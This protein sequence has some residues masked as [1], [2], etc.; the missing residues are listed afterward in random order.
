MYFSR[1]LAA[2]PSP[3]RGL[4]ASSA[5]DRSWFDRRLTFETLDPRILLSADL[6]PLHDNIVTAGQINR[7]HLTLAQP[8]TI[9]ADSGNTNPGLSWRLDAGNIATIMP[10]S[11]SPAATADLGGTAKLSLPAGDYTLSV[12]GDVNA[13]GS[14]DL[15]LLDTSKAATIATGTPT[16]G[17]L[18]AGQADLYHFDGQ[19]GE[20]VFLDTRTMSGVAPAFHLVGPNGELLGA[21]DAGSATLGP[22]TLD[23]NGEYTLRV[24][25][26]HGASDYGFTVFASTA[27][28]TAA[29]TDEVISGHLAAPG[30]LA[31]Y[32]FSVAQQSEIGLD[33]LSGDS[34]LHFTLLGSA[35][36]AISDWMA[37]ATTGTQ[38][39]H[40][41]IL[42]PG[43]Y[44][45]VVRDTA[46][47]PSD[48][49]F[50]AFDPPLPAA[51]ADTGTRAP[52][53]SG[54]LATPGQADQYSFTL[55]KESLLYFD[56]VTNNDSINWS[57]TGPRGA[58]VNA[59]AFSSSDAENVGSPL[60]TL[61]AGNYTLSVQANG[62]RTGAYGFR[63]LDLSKAQPITPGVPVTATL[64]ANL[65]NETD[66][67]SFTANAGQRLYLNAISGGNIYWRL[68][69]PFGNIIGSPNY[70][71]DQSIT[72]TSSGTYTLLV[73]GRI[74]SAAANT[75]SF[76]VNIDADS[77]A[78]LVLGQ[79]T[80]GAVTQP[81]QLNNYTFAQ[82]GETR[83]V[84][85]ALTLDTSLLWSLTGPAGQVIRQ[86]NFAS[87]DSLSIGGDSTALDLPGGAYTLTVQGSGAH[88]SQYA[89]RLLDLS[90]GTKT[91]YDT[92]ISA[93]LGDAGA[94]AA[95]VAGAAATD[96]LLV[97][98]GTINNAVNF[99][100]T[101]AYAQVADKAALRP[102]QVTVEAW[103]YYDPN[104]P[105][106]GTIA[107]K[108]SNGSWQDG[109]GL[110]RLPSGVGFY[111]N[112]YNNHFITT[113]LT[114]NAW[115]HVAAT[116]D[117]TTMVL[118]VNGVAVASQA[119][120]AAIVYNGST[121]ANAMPLQIGNAVGG[122]SWSGQIDELQ[123]WNVARSAADIAASYQQAAT[124]TEAGLVGLWHFDEPS[125][126]TTFADASPNNAVATLVNNAPGRE[127]RVYTFDAIAGDQVQLAVTQN[128]NSIY[129]RL[130]DPYGAQV[131]AGSLGNTSLQTL[132][133]TGTYALL[134][135][136]Y[137]YNS[138][139]ASYTFMIA[140]PSSVPLPT[141]TGIALTLGTPVSVPTTTVNETDDYIF[142]I[143]GPA[144]FNFAPLTTPYFTSLSANWQL[145]GPQGRVTGPNSFY[146]N[147]F[148]SLTVPGTYRLRVTDPTAGQHYSFRLDDET[149]GAEVTY[150]TARSDALST[151][152]DT[153]YYTFTAAAGDRVYFEVPSVS[154]SM[155]WYLLD[156]YTNTVF[157]QG[158]ASTGPYTMAVGGTYTLVIGGQYYNSTPNSS[159][160]F[161][162]DQIVD[163]TAAM[164]LGST[165]SGTLTQPGQTADYTFSLANPAQ[166]YFAAISPQNG[167]FYWT[168]TGPSGVVVSNTYLYEPYNRELSLPAGNY[169]LRISGN[170]AAIGAFSFRMLDLATA[171]SF[172]YGDVVT[173]ASATSPLAV[174]LYKFNAAAGDNVYFNTLANSD[175][176]LQWQVLDPFGR[177]FIS[178]RGFSTIGR[179]VLPYAGAYTVVVDAAY[180]DPATTTNFSFQVLKET[181]TTTAL[182]AVDGPA[183]TGPI[184]VAGPNGPALSFTGAE[185]VAVPNSAA[186]DL[187]NQ[188]TIS[189]W[190]NPTSFQNT[191]AN[192]VY[193]GDGINYLSR[194]YS[195]WLNS[196]GSIYLGTSDASGHQSLQTANG[197]IRAGVWTYVTAEFDR[198]S[199]S[200]AVY[201]NGV[202]AVAG[203]LRTG[204]AVDNAGPLV[205]GGQ[206]EAADVGADAFY[207]AMQ[208]LSISST[209]LNAA[210]V[211]S[212]YTTTL[213]G[214]EANLALYLPMNEATGATALTD[215]SANN[216]PV[217]VTSES[218]GL[219][220][221]ITGRFATPG[222]IQKYTF[223]LLSP[224]QL[225]FDGLT[226]NSNIT[227]TLTGPNGLN[228][229]RNLRNGDSFEWGST[230]PVIQ[231][232][233]GSYTITVADSSSAL[234]VYAF[235]FVNLADAQPV[236]LN[237]LISGALS[238]GAATQA[239]RFTANAGDVI[240]LNALS[241]SL[242]IGS[243]YTSLRLID[244]LGNQVFGPNYF[245]DVG[246]T[247]LAYTGTYTLLVEG[248]SWYP[249]PET[250]SFRINPVVNQTVALTLGTNPNP[251]PVWDETSPPTTGGVELTGAEYVS[252][253]DSAALDA[254]GDVTIEAWIKVDR[255]PQTWAPI[256]YKGDATNGNG[257]GRTYSLWLNSNGSIY[258]G[259]AAGPGGPQGVQTGGGLVTPGTWVH[260]AGVIDRT[261]GQVHAYVN[262]VDVAD[263]GISTV[264]GPVAAQ[265]L[266]IGGTQ[267]VNPAYS[268]F[269]GTVS[270]VRV[271]S[272]VRS[273]SQILA[274]KNTALVGTEAN[275]VLDLPF[276]EGA[277][278]TTADISPNAGTATIQRL[279]A[280][281]VT[282]QITSPG[283]QA[284]YTFTLAADRQ[285]YFDA[286]LADSNLYWTLSGPGGT[287]VSG[288]QFT[289]SDANRG[290][291]LLSL[292]AG[293][294]QLT[295]NFGGA[296]TGFYNFR[297]LDFSAAT[298][299]TL[300]TPVNVLLNP[301]NA[302]NI[303]KF[304]ATAGERV[305][306]DQLADNGNAYFRVIDPLGRD[307]YGAIWHDSLPGFGIRTLSLDGT[308]TIIVDS[309][310]Y[311]DPDRTSFTFNVSQVIDKTAAMTSGTAVQG[312]ID[313]PGQ[314]ANYT[315]TVA[316]PTRAF[317]DSLTNNSGFYWTITG[318]NGTVISGRQFQNAD[319]YD[320][321]GSNEL[322][323]APGD[324]TVT[325]TGYQD[326]TGAFSFNLLDG[327]AATALTLGTPVTT[328]QTA[329]TT[330]L[331]SFT[332]NQLDRVQL[333]SSN[334][335]GDVS[336]RLLDPLGRVVFGPTY[337]GNSQGIITLPLSGTYLLEI[338]GR[339]Y[340]GTPISYTLNVSQV[341]QPASGGATTQDFETA[342]N[343]LPWVNDIY[344]SGS[345]AQVVVTGGASPNKFLRLASTLN[346]NQDNN[347]SFSATGT[348]P[349]GSVQV[350]YD[351][352]MA[353]GTGRSGGIL[354]SL[355]DTG[356]YGTGGP[357]YDPRNGVSAA[358][359]VGLGAGGAANGASD[360]VAVYRYNATLRQ[361]T[362]PFN[363]A[364]GNFSHARVIAQQVD[365]GAQVTVILTPSGGG[366]PVTVIDH[367]FIGGWFPDSFRLVFNG[368]TGSATMN[369]DIDNLAIA[370]TPAAPIPSMTLDSIV[371]GNIVT[372][373]ATERY[374]FTP[375]APTSAVF[376]SLAN[377]G[378]LY[379]SI[380]GP[381]GSVISGRQFQN[382]DSWD[383]GGTS[384]VINLATSTY[385]VSIA[386]NDSTS[387][388][389]FSFRLNQL[390]TATPL[391]IGTAVN[392]TLNPAAGTGLYS[393]T[394]TAGDFFYLSGLS[395]W[396]GTQY[397]KVLDPNGT[398]VLFQQPLYQN[399]GFTA[400]VSGTY[401]LLIEGRYYATGAS[402]F[403]FT[404]YKPSFTTTALT[405]NTTVSDSIK[406]PGA[407]N[408]YSFTL[409]APT[410]L[411]WNSQTNDYDL[412]YV[413]TGPGGATYLVA[414]S[415]SD[416]T[417]AIAYAPAGQYTLTIYNGQNDGHTGPYS[418]R[419]LD[420]IGGATAVTPGTLV[421]DT[422][423][424][425]TGQAAY[426]ITTRDTDQQLY[427]DAPTHS[428]SMH[429][430]LVNRAGG[431]LF[432]SNFQ[433][434]GFLTLAAN[435]T[436]ALVVSGYP[437]NG[438]T[439]NYT[440]SLQPQT[441]TTSALVLGAVTSGAISIAGETNS[442]TFTLANPTRL[443]LGALSDTI[444]NAYPYD[445]S[446]VA[447][448]TGPGGV[449][450]SRYLNAGAGVVYNNYYG[451]NSPIFNLPAGLYTLTISSSNDSTG[452]YSFRLQDVGAA[453]PI[454][455][456]SPVTGTLSPGSDSS[457]FTFTARAGDRIFVDPTIAPGHNLYWRLVDPN[458]AQVF[459]QYGNTAPGAF[460]LSVTGTYTLTLEG[461]LGDAGAT[462]SFGFAVYPAPLSAP[463]PI[464]T[465]G[466]VLAPDLTVTNLAANATPRIQAGGS[467][468]V[469][470][471][472][473]NIGAQPTD[474]SWTDRVVVRRAD[475]NQI[476]ANVTVPYDATALGALPPD[477]GQNQHISFQLPDGD[478]GSGALIISV[479]T[480]IGNTVA[481]RNGDGTAYSNNTATLNIMSVL[482]PYPDLQVK[483][484]GVSPTT[485]YKPGDQVTVSWT[486]V[487]A[488]TADVTV[489]FQEQ[490]SVRNL[491][492]G[493]VILL[494]SQQFS[495]SQ[496][497]PFAA[498]ATA[499]RSMI[500][501]WPSGFNSTGQFE[502]DITVD[503][504][505]QVIEAVPFVSRTDNTGSTTALS[506]PD[507]A[508]SGLHVVSPTTPRS[509]STVTIGWT[510][511]NN[512]N[513]VTPVGWND[514]VRVVNLTTGALIIV[515]AVDAGGVLAPGATRARSFAF[516]LPDGNAGVG[517]IQVTVTLDQTPQGQSAIDEAN[518]THG[519]NVRANNTA[520]VNFTSILAL[521]PDLV[522]ALM[523][524]ATGTGGATINV[525]WTVTNNGA[526]ATAAGSWS[527]KLVLSSSPTIGAASDVVLGFFPHTGDLAA[528]ASY[529]QTQTVT[530]P[531]KLQGNYYI[532]VVADTGQAVLEPNTRAD[533]TSTVQPIAITSPAADLAPSNVTA[534]AS[535][536]IGG[537]VTIGWNV[538]NNGSQT[539][540]LASWND[541][542][543]LSESTTVQ[544]GD[545]LLATIPHVG[546]L[547]VGASYNATTTVNLPTN[548]AGTFNILVVTNADGL[549]Y[550]NGQTGNNTAASGTIVVHSPDL[551]A[552]TLTLPGLTVPG[553]PTTATLT[554]RNDGDAS[555]TA[556]WSDAIYLST[557]PS[558]T[559][560]TY[561]TQ[562]PHSA[563][564]AGGGAYTVTIPLTLPQFSDGTYYLV[565]QTD[566]GGQVYEAARANN[567]VASAGFAL[568]HPDL[569]P[570]GA[571]APAS[572]TS[573]QP[574]TVTWSD[575]NR[576]TGPVLPGWTDTV[577]LSANGAIDANAV[578]LGSVSN[579]GPLAAGGAIAQSLTAT[580]PI[581][582]SGAYQVLIQTDSNNT[583]A[584]LPANE[585]NN[586]V[587]LPLTVTLAPYADLALSNV[588][589]PALTV[590]DP[591]TVTIG[592]TVTNQGT[593]IGQ[594]T[595]WDDAVIASPDA[596]VG[597]GDDIVIGRFTHDGPL[598]V[599][600]SYTQ[601]QQI[602]LAPG[603]IGRYHLFVQADAGRVVFQNGSTGNDAAQLATPFDVSP[604]PYAD[605]VVSSVTPDAGGSSG[606]PLKLTWTVQNQGIGLTD[607]SDWQD[608]VYISP[609]ADGSGSTYLGAFSHIGFITPGQG[610]TRSATVT[611]PDTYSGPAYFFVD[612]PGSINPQGGSPYEFIYTNNNRGFS[613]QTQIAATPSPDLIVSNIIVPATASE[614]SAVDV[615]W[616]V[617]NQG[618][619][620][621]DGS[622]TDQVYLHKVGDTG[623][624]TAIGSYT[625]T[626]PLGAGLSY[627]RREQI[628]LPTHTSDRYEVIVTT[629]ADS[630][631]FER[632]P[633]DA[634]DTTVSA[635]A[636]LVSVLPRPDLQIAS[637]EAPDTIDAGAS[638]SVAF[639]IINQG[640]V[641]T[642]IPHWTDNV[643]LS[644]DSKI[645]SDDIVISS[646]QNGSALDPGQS[647]RTEAGSFIVPLRFRGTVY[648][649][650]E[651]NV[652]RTMDEWPN[653]DNNISIHPLY[654]N[655]KPFAD[656]VVSDV[657]TPALSFEGN[658]LTVTY[659]VTNRGA[660]PTNLGNYAEQIWLT[661]DKHRPSPSK[662]DVLLKEIQYTGGILAVGQGYDRSV[663]VTLPDHVVSGTYYITPWVDPYETLLQ[664]E[665]AINVNPD[666]PH[667]INNDNYKAGGA[668]V[669]GLKVIGT[670]A[671]VPDLQVVS[672]N[673]DATGTGG[674]TFKAS[675]TVIN[676]GDGT[677]T[678]VTDQVFLADQPTLETPGVNSFYL[679]SF[680]APGDLAPGKSYTQ[681]QSFLLN[682]AA[683][684]TYFIV[685]NQ[686]IDAT[687][688]DNENSAATNVVAPLPDLQVTSVQAAASAD[689]GEKTSITY[690]VTNTGAAA[691]WSGTKY[692][693]DQIWISRDSTFIASRAINV[694]SVEH[695]GD[696]LA[697]GASY[698]ETTN[699]TLPPG[700]GGT[701]H[702]YVFT[703]V[704][705]S[706]APSLRP[707]PFNN[708]DNA[709]L[710]DQTFQSAA[711]EAPTGNMGTTILPVVYKEPDLKVTD[712]V[713]PATI[714]AG[715]T[716]DISFTVTN[717]GNR[718][719][720]E[721]GWTDRVYLSLDASL[722][723]GDYLLPLRK[724]D[725]TFADAAFLRQGVL[726][727][728]DS[729]VA[730]IR[731]TLPFEVKGSFYLLAYT[732]SG[733]GASGF[734]PST[735]S[736]R[737]QGIAGN[738]GGVVREFQGEGNNV[739]AAAVQITP[740]VAPDLQVTEVDAPLR[741]TRGQSFSV[742]YT[743]T[744][745]GGD[746]PDL[747]PAWDDLIYLSRDQL[748]DL[749]ADR[750]IGTLRHTTGLAAGAAYTNTLTFSVPSDL[751]TDAYYV[752]VV[753][754]PARYNATGEVFES[755]ERNNA[756]PS[757]A[758]MVID[759]PPPTDLQVDEVDGPA[760]ARAGEPIHIS[761]NVSDHSATVPAS[762]A[763]T[764]AV[765]LSPDA[766]WHVTDPV[767]G[768]ITFSGTLA[769]AQGYTL[770][771]DGTMPAAAPGDYR[772]IVR[773][774]IYHQ[775]YEGVFAANNTTASANATTVSVD[776]LTLGIPLTTTLMAGQARLYQLTV[777]EGQTLRVKLT[778][779]NDKS[780]NTIY[781]R[782]D[783]A[784]TT[785]VYDATSTGAL[786]S[787]LSALVPSTLPGTY[788]VLVKGFT[789]PAGGSNITLLAEDLPLLIT[790][791]QSDRGGDSKF[792]TVTVTGA[793]FAPQAI[794]KLVRPDIAEYEPVNWQV[795]NSAEI[796]ATF[797]LTDAPHGLYDLVVTNPDG[798]QA[799]IP[800]RFLVE[801]AVEPEVTIGIG[802]P[803]V[804]LAGDT[805][806]YSI[807][808]DNISNLDAPYT[809]FQVGI[810]QLN[811]N[812]IV[813]GLP[814]VT[815]ATNVAGAPDNQAGSAN[816]SVPYASIDSITNT[817]GQLITSGYLF[818][819]PDGG[820]AGF[821]VN[822][823]TYPGLKALHDRA[824]DAFRAEMATIA[825]DLDSKLAN[826]PGGLQ[827]WWD[828][829]KQKAADV[830]PQF[831]DILDQ[832]DF[833]GLYNQ[834]EAVPN[835]CVVPFIPFRF[836]IFAAATSMTRDEFIAHI[837]NE[838]LTIRD[839][840]LASLTTAAP[841]PAPLI[842]LVADKQ[843]FVDLELAALEQ[844][845]ILR[846]DGA[847]PPIRTRQDIQSLMSV[848]ASGILFGPAGTD[849]RSTGDLLSF[850]DQ[851]RALYGNN[852]TTM[853]ALDGYDERMSDC[854]TY[855]IPLPSI[856]QFSDYNLNLSQPTQF[857]AFRV[858]VPW[859]PFEDRGA[860]L[861]ADFQ[862][863]LAAPVE[864]DP[865]KALDFSRYFNSQGQ[866]N[867][868]ASITGPQ[869]LDSQGYL[870]VNTALP[871][872]VNFENSAAASTYVNS[873][874]I[875]TQL[876]PSLDASTFT[877]GDI[878]V[879]DITVHV[880]A[881]QHFFSQDIDFTATRGFILRVTA[882][883]DLYQNPAAATWLIQAID[884]LTGEVLTDATRGLLKPNDAQGTGAGFVS[885][886]A[887]AK[888]DIA[889]GTHI[890]AKARV[891][892]DT[893]PPEDTETLDQVV[894]GLPPTSTVTVKQLGGS[895]NYA[896]TWN[897]T[898]DA[899]GSGFQHVTL[900]VA[901]DGGDFKIWQRQLTDATGT[902]VY[903]GQAGHTYEFLALA[904]DN[905]GNREAPPTDVVAA[906]DGSQPT[907]GSTPSVPDTTPANF[908]IPPTPAPTPSTNPLFTAAE[909]DLPSVVPVTHASEFQSVL[910]PFAAQSFA[911]GVGASEAGIA[912]V[913]LLE[914]PDGTFLVAG[915]P[916]RGT[917]YKVP[918]DG[919]ANATVW[920]T[921]DQPVFNMAFDKA[922]RL[923][924]TTGG[925][926]LLRLDPVS[927][928]VLGHYGDGITLALAVDPAGGT[929]YVGTNKGVSTF[930]PDTGTFT[931]WSRDE[932]LRVSSLAF[933]PDGALWGVTW[934]DRRQVVRF[935]DHKRAVTQL[936]FD[937]DIDSIAFGQ[938]GTALARLLFVSHNA[939]PVLDTGAA[940][941][942]SE[943]TM[944]DVAT[945]R[946]VALATGGTRGGDLI[947]TSDGRV[948][949][950]QSH[951]VDVVNPVFAPSVIATNPPDKAV[952]PLPL[953]YLS[954]TFD[955][956]MLAA[957]AT[958]AGS[959]LNPANYV[960][961]GAVVGAVTPTAI[962]Y[963]AATRTV[964]LTV[965]TLLADTYTLTIRSTV[966]SA[967]ALTLGK[968]YTVSFQGLDDLTGR[969][970]IR[971]AGTR[972]DRQTGLISYDL[973]ITNTSG[974]DL[975][976]PALLVLD[977]R[978]GATG[979]PQST[980]GRT[981]DGRWLVDLSASLPA[982]GKL[983]VGASITGTTVSISTPD[984]HREDFSVGVTAN[985]A[986][987]HAPTF[988][989]TPPTAAI[990]VG[991]VFTYAARA[992]DAD[993]NAIIYRLLDGPDNMTMDPATGNVSWVVPANA[994]AS[995]QV[996]LQVFDSHGASTVQSFTITVT[997]GNQPPQ[998][999]GLASE[1000]DGAEGQQISFIATGTDPQSLP[1001]VVTA[1002]GLPPGS[1003]FDP[1004]T[1005]TF[1006][1007][1008]PGYDQAGTYKNA[1009][1010]SISDGISTVTQSVTFVISQAAKPVRL[1011]PAPARTLREGDRLVFDLHGQGDA[1012]KTLTYSA[1013]DLPYGATLDP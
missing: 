723:D 808:L 993:G 585:A 219:P 191:W 772:I 891:L 182:P 560:T 413:L 342:G 887:N 739:T 145:D 974:S 849:I 263:A 522:P 307:L 121:A 39:N 495:A 55:S 201:L 510:D 431:V 305:Y 672:V 610:Y 835:D 50:R 792:V 687:P 745:E 266:L 384:P 167:N 355:V 859:V 112:S 506:A 505:G 627:T 183:I 642:T 108:A 698:T 696:S 233:A 500:F 1010:F 879:G 323:L 258:I 824:F 124:G 484:V 406:Q 42:D 873:I 282:G 284:I 840:I 885:W 56:S 807:A 852:D 467:V 1001:L 912:P 89:F 49:T 144:R 110:A 804:I 893:Q 240:Y 923:W 32:S 593:G 327:G 313:V 180:Y 605:L 203:G 769:P 794:V 6:L 394:A 648:I 480:D 930:D 695:S 79:S 115:S 767:L 600:Q 461:Y 675:W 412:D 408:S 320:F 10:R 906:D 401:T 166:L 984:R 365:G 524:P 571:S 538:T 973:T 727:A 159:Y 177:V 713:V 223:T 819:Q 1009:V 581:G 827:D 312:T 192:L 838:A 823:S 828:A 580:L 395:G 848:L 611:I 352:R 173:G 587:S 405:L 770:T 156:P 264:A 743:V 1004:A 691:I 361:V 429:W 527:D 716:I 85:D 411:S 176:Y 189:F 101:A 911:Q 292:A 289:S 763:W 287:I 670:P 36:Q 692:W 68:V 53:I 65:G 432:N 697:A 163:T 326:T 544:P 689:S 681:T 936:K 51:S 762:G 628:I 306:F 469:S 160:N 199:G 953:P 416:S 791:V 458:N 491:T 979:L 369:Q 777:P 783:A 334:V 960:L 857:E 322:D 929:I 354:M 272:A 721:T 964:L 636:I 91:A 641:S 624:G 866:T 1003:S 837:S 966:A 154:G 315:F 399:N 647:Y 131:Y 583:V 947:T 3:R 905:A 251:G 928:A 129:V 188:V 268:Y 276:K 316:S 925:N 597:N 619:G 252:V 64:P 954:V 556:P 635:Q 932:N 200:M 111:V 174:N 513:V 194:T 961:T 860:G 428:N 755:N 225:V 622:W 989:T 858:Y 633:A 317:F 150:G 776:K 215:H 963:D 288:R 343:G 818:D 242:G 46:G 475:N 4:N 579:A 445:T 657:V 728:G 234:D 17:T 373:G 874:Q 295:I 519:V 278:V 694:G 902:L 957:N 992:T 459:Y 656:L 850:F 946:T 398:P 862:N 22:V 220:G 123:V 892:F 294:Y 536:L 212:L 903:Q 810:P 228:V 509:G 471:T 919:S 11:V 733:L 236:A 2:N 653:A 476:L 790:D 816:A 632:P 666:D 136:G 688:V 375:T 781:L 105:T 820:F 104:T 813:Y 971:I 899:G 158:L 601:S 486:D 551:V 463:V 1012:G 90:A 21:P 1008:V 360:A 908:G 447:T 555:A 430:L 512:G 861:P 829:F 422:L 424:P 516:V 118:Y 968:D 508:I 229:S 941:P 846:P 23:A 438:G 303:Y 945:L 496:A 41:V 393:F 114:P 137:I 366:A 1007:W 602:T 830:N 490:V 275:L 991:S 674:T 302:A 787:D 625:Y 453:T 386:H 598:A 548:L 614:G 358:L 241:N 629:N 274:G 719:T 125:G 69:D 13:T 711:F 468:T 645:S 883:V 782:H 460:T 613:A 825:P 539:T 349:Y 654:V 1002:D 640:P 238:N 231:A 62:D 795:V 171:T 747:Q 569:A 958:A 546:A 575:T 417:L 67:Y 773:T 179:Q 37:P 588:T 283:Q 981:D 980:T 310:V 514:R 116:Y 1000:V 582:A 959:V 497:S 140:H 26:N 336:W 324:Y 464:D 620:E 814:Y 542:I 554:V 379:W 646:L 999:V 132:L 99:A 206:A 710:R 678:G 244:P 547:G 521:Y 855:D 706:S 381:N 346:Q 113:S 705:N 784:P 895:N 684:G 822:L 799:I 195:I 57:L 541:R 374:Q 615:T 382:S 339:I 96:G 886:S 584:E 734:A 545:A 15:H 147:Q 205:I 868:L 478:A 363:L 756:R 213:T 576:G 786:A 345:P 72:V 321:G 100:G 699:V 77:T 86:R 350:D 871:Y 920:V 8:A 396:N 995:E 126:A 623:P 59:R 592:W 153:K 217:T 224:A 821:S 267:E 944:V 325:I 128:T 410:L 661:T 844:A 465:V 222:Q 66:L 298:P 301:G 402:S 331:Y 286:L 523:V 74:Y 574:V 922:G 744:N 34:N 603:F 437:S 746:T 677:A 752:F 520:S 98:G 609:N 208:D 701:Y 515:Q 372:G 1011:D 245:Q 485:G 14:Y 561:L 948:L 702:V 483:T 457:A 801:R 250:Y 845:G 419:L 392:G 433:P 1005:R 599:G 279:N 864:T 559:G 940:S 472:D 210:Q 771:L 477:M 564:L 143:A 130:F 736:P 863:S 454:T 226:N 479:T 847:T 168:L 407:Q 618:A 347:A 202:L 296:E 24:D 608:N 890:T 683:K 172:N 573:G 867:R 300:G 332:A 148:L 380:T 943:L 693:T 246:D 935:T 499:T 612:V 102:A 565:A 434:Q 93:T 255:M 257:Y 594:T 738:P 552:A 517:N 488:G 7:Q 788:Y 106:Y 95:L 337:L 534:P 367:T 669:L 913:G 712:F 894:D 924:A 639:T 660:G 765:Y 638:A 214:T 766:T 492:T 540:N 537:P 607:V 271:W 5:L 170:G 311:Y 371:S 754:D 211:A 230:N 146:Y 19:A 665:L 290:S 877:L 793:Q 870:P 269:K 52:V 94:T 797:D 896:V 81:G 997:N 503:S 916:N 489:P 387:T 748:L 956:D 31:T 557:N 841:A 720:R 909:K 235:R 758:P 285:L 351:F 1006:S 729:Y 978:N 446:L 926:A 501:A 927:G 370:T 190:L 904:T 742:T 590:D 730:M 785:A 898:D 570:T 655:P 741:V 831:K 878:K 779:D 73:E 493:Q 29:T 977:P 718:A 955:Q 532:A 28:A 982:N 900:Y 378:S 82:P 481:E 528:G 778:S 843:R 88:Q 107:V 668:D 186:I 880:P 933:G 558:L 462:I 308:Y 16:R 443:L 994:T 452:T 839:N 30:D 187:R 662:G 749:R 78:P 502:F 377:D 362:A 498:G 280:H 996:A 659:T 426:T 299:I 789:G 494:Q 9:V 248:R 35:G 652:G 704:M 802:G 942:G 872:T 439:A 333:S 726:A 247:A 630:T 383:L 135:E 549:V 487:N 466:V 686:L 732:D 851:L 76:G 391:T 482:P 262:G 815:M 142:T 507:L 949:I 389:G 243:G 577:W 836:H 637:I 152:L 644:L 60:L 127:T 58:E 854:Y 456:G 43:A 293:T 33:R 40:S 910:A 833:V 341:A 328:T 48:F 751:P 117:G 80:Y 165:V 740:Y 84:F 750:Y 216:L 617:T 409:A 436:Y 676:H 803:R 120:S 856:P 969:V 435:Q 404:L 330:R 273:A 526:A 967:A 888:T 631:L 650:V 418:F 451:S 663:N 87:S 449:V 400:S 175:G 196:G 403:G 207:G 907:V 817:N 901:T 951:E 983:A 209:A 348:G 415:L 155:F 918:H 962:V 671:P 589:G 20:T 133:L 568:V 364:D 703:N 357:S 260:V 318:P 761:W 38:D 881:G 441:A 71:G 270:D 621:A 826:G 865:F 151:P 390:S 253:P 329:Q 314:A 812:D 425:A 385:V 232:P 972:F 934:P 626:G 335:S 344:G 414:R 161:K 914:M 12:Y 138:A 937:S 643:W 265:P 338:E 141:L 917:L 717:V 63:L 634:N 198:S 567:I 805:Q 535:G 679:G 842:A 595:R 420:L 809:F 193:K 673:P 157:S 798:S 340:T 397:Y 950:S 75:Y 533:S 658:G 139:P 952:L 83:A 261:H 709:Q 975:I 586:I 184:S 780:I 530:L 759:L 680:A 504:A 596:V 985:A 119:Y 474:A 714:Q 939:G 473:S 421:T 764:D 277:G 1:W 986:P 965:G 444:N 889:T 442:F 25:A 450:L 181:D 44:T 990:S 18:A 731:V 735:I 319:S 591:A 27:S 54:N 562:L 869:T 61:L 897:S 715:S 134:V 281:G 197:S 178:D 218:A 254:T 291:P 525:S 359:A 708:G 853:A 931:Q 45:V 616:T 309:D 651:T 239:Y 470:W 122:A 185:A 376:D 998:F 690:T 455:L 800:Y 427:F 757:A 649:I 970:A 725:G 531:A 915:G 707:W 550:E 988:T 423:N 448:L 543:Y 529:T 832:I 304:N 834:N 162:I 47:A 204:L 722:D 109:W 249:P 169:A 256:I 563:D 604:I 368:S 553:V 149:A 682:P 876:D 700:I 811:N 353:A 92:A 259:T 737:L 724:P 882:G 938:A 774:D 753:T 606:Q 388:G 440:F 237:T 806:T 664:D 566:S 103:V 667:E 221:T 164:T 976:I 796:I 70:F 884:P 987:N 921:L 768:R 572:V 227:V 685:K 297:L 875:V 578:K 97:P 356:T 511:A 1013:D 518:G 775:E 760:T